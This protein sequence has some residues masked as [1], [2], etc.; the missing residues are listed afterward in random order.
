MILATETSEN[1][2]RS[3]YLILETRTGRLSARTEIGG[4]LKQKT[5]AG[6]TFHAVRQEEDEAR[7]ADPLGLA[8]RDELV[9]DALG[10]VEKVAELRLPADERVRV[11]HRVAQLEAQHAELGQRTVAHRVR[12][13]SSSS[14]SSPPKKRSTTFQNHTSRA[15]QLDSKPEQKGKLDRNHFKNVHLGLQSNY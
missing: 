3:Y 5:N 7:L 12:R 1:W 4:G 8:G 11:R 9:D 10:R 15:A 6:R 13:L 14:S 2:A